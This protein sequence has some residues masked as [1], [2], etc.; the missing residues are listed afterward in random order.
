M[1]CEAPFYSK[2][3]T[4]LEVDYLCEL[5]SDKSYNINFLSDDNLVVLRNC[6]SDGQLVNLQKN[7]TKTKPWILLLVKLFSDQ[8]KTEHVPICQS[9]CPELL[10]V[11]DE[12]DLNQLASR[13]CIHSKVTGHI[14]RDFTNTFFTLDDWLKISE[15]FDDEGR[16]IE[17]IHRRTDNTTKSHHL[18]VC[19]MKDRISLL[20]T[21]GRMLRPACSN[22]HSKCK[23]IKYFDKKLEDCDLRVNFK[24]NNKATE[25][26][27]STNNDKTENVEYGYNKSKIT[28]PLKWCPVQAEIFENRDSRYSLPSELCPEVGGDEDVCK[29][30]NHFSNHRKH[31]TSEV[32]SVFHDQGEIFIPCRVYSLRLPCKCQ[33]QM[34]LHP[35]L[36]YHLGSGKTVD[37]VTLQKFCLYLSQGGTTTQAYYNSIKNNCRALNLEVYLTYNSFLAACDGFVR[38]LGW[39]KE[40]VFSC[41]NCGT[42]PRAFVGKFHDHSFQRKYYISF[43]LFQET[44]NATLR[45]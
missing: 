2:L 18:A 38:N 9:C 30:G 16:K 14:I 4:K 37:Y 25:D 23:C 36:L 34:D 32:I 10:S 35:Y 12:T 39:D 26:E 20:W 15:D 13:L 29:H 27:T 7:D 24:V 44:V 41:K 33:K 42:S 17:F 3:T 43:K 28:L 45:R 6:E 31:L 22:C 19:F 40:K 8:G 21:R 1:A 11:D 5:R